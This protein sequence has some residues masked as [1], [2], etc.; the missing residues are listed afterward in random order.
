MLS[1]D[2]SVI[3]EEHETLDTMEGEDCIANVDEE[4]GGIRMAKEKK[5]IRSVSMPAKYM[6]SMVKLMEEMEREE[7]KPVKIPVD[8]VAEKDCEGAVETTTHESEEAIV[9]ERELIIHDEN[10]DREIKDGGDGVGHDKKPK[11][12]KSSKKKKRMTLGNIDENFQHE[13]K[14]HEGSSQAGTSGNEEGMNLSM[15]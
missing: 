12:E 10:P 14:K 6:R 1:K 3:Q 13:E 4:D 5:F 9:S 11:N 2:D 7:N 8:I 15:H